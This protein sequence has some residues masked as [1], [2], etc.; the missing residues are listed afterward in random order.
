MARVVVPGVPHHVTQRGVRKNDVFFCKEDYELYI[1]LL[2]EF[3]QK[4]GTEIW[5]Y[6][7]MTNHIHLVMVPSTVDGLRAS[8]GEAH[9]RYT[10][11]INQRE[12][13]RGHLWQERFH[14]FPMD[15]HY[16]LSAVRY[17]ELNPVH[18]NM[19]DCPEDY[20]WSS[21]RAHLA[22]QDDALVK[23]SPMLDRISDWQA[24]LDSDLDDATMA[25][26]RTHTQTGRPLG[27]D[28]FVD[29]LELN[30]GRVLRSLKQGRKRVTDK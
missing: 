23:V 19:V 12:Q 16:L 8:L 9:R 1:S 25:T 6:C 11:H 22:G 7:L 4:S 21:A 17:V 28:S 13:C 3:S 15:E 26:L 5:S 18:A 10:R 14:S 2:S 20:I 29:M 30:A 27:D 24:Y